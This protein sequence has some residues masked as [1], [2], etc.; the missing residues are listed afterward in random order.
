MK[1]SSRNIKGPGR[2][3][4]MHSCQFSSQDSIG[5]CL[6]SWLRMPYQLLQS[7]HVSRQ[8]SNMKSYLSQHYISLSPS[9]MQHQ[10][11]SL[12]QHHG[13]GTILTHPSGKSRS[14]SEVTYKLVGKLI[15]VLTGHGPFPCQ[16]FPFVLSYLQVKIS[17]PGRK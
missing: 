17:V 3:H 15:K 14:P 8:P 12:S 4:D 10:V 11:E 6:G 1:A 13:N 16:L 5:K 2:L 7:M 9:S